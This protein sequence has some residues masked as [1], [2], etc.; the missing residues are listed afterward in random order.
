MKHY[1]KSVAYPPQQRPDSTTHGSAIARAKTPANHSM[2]SIRFTWGNLILQFTIQN[3]KDSMDGEGK[4]G[5]S[6]QF[7]VA[8]ISFRSQIKT[9]VTYLGKLLQIIKIEFFVSSRCVVQIQFTQRT[10]GTSWQ[11]SLQIHS[12]SISNC[13]KGIADIASIAGQHATWLAHE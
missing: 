3:D 10:F 5:A 4:N 6:I 1:P 11:A 8:A 2:Q 7:S 12:Q 13:G 9:R